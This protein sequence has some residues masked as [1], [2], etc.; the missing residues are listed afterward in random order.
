M[1]A[2]VATVLPF[3]FGTLRLHR[4]EAA[5]IPATPPRSGCSNTPV[6][7]AKASP[8]NISASTGSGRTICCSPGCGTIR[9]LDQTCAGLW[10]AMVP[11]YKPRTRGP[12][13]L[14]GMMRVV[15]P[16]DRLR[17]AIRVARRSAGRDPGGLRDGSLPSLSGS[18]PNW[19]TRSASS[20]CR[21]PG[22]GCGGGPA[23]RRGLPVHRY[24]HR[25][26]HAG[27]RSQGPAGDRD[28][29]RYQ[30]TFTELARQCFVEAARCGCASA[31]RAAPS[32]AR[33]ARRRRS[34]FRSATRSCRR[35]CSPRPSSPSSGAC[36]WRRARQH[37]V[38]RHRGGP[39]L[40]DAADGAAAAY[41][42]YVGFD[43]AADR[44]QAPAKKAPK[45]KKKLDRSVAPELR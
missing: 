34:P 18:M 37:D 15:G 40:P 38:H 42:V 14:P 44:S 39:E 12:C 23:A 20:G 25:R 28:D 9:R 24:P 31:C 41:V 36:R 17:C 11:C 35:A 13:S 5:C 30:L 3:A 2:A 43:E 1:T 6:S 26:R 7:S 19:F 29:L 32:S 10:A 8:A 45:A 21:G 27:G 22:A 16:N 33:P 4:V